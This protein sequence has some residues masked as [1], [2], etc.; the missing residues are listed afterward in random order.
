MDTTKTLLGYR[1][2]DHNGMY[3]SA[4]GRVR[5]YTKPEPIT[6]AQ[7]YSAVASFLEHN[8][9]S[10]VP[11]VVKVFKKASP[12]QSASSEL[13]ALLTSLCQR[14]GLD[15]G[16]TQEQIDRQIAR[17]LSELGASKR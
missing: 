3:V 10:P 4:D 11:Q 14:H 1:V 7:A 17:E 12:I 16:L 15:L 2:K 8:S 6:H 13:G 9:W 5:T